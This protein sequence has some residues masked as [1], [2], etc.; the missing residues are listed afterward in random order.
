MS[1]WRAAKL[2]TSAVSCGEPQNRFT[3]LNRFSRQHSHYYL[4]LWCRSSRLRSRTP[5]RLVG[6]T[7][8]FD[9]EDD[10]WDRCALTEHSCQTIV[11]GASNRTQCVDLRCPNNPPGLAARKRQGG[12]GVEKTI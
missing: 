1:N 9:T 12:R 6:S 7:S 4:H 11:F 8:K 5:R 3:E 2:K 10:R